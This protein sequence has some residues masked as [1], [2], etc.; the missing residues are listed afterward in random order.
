MLG[1]DRREREP[2]GPD[3]ILETTEK[4]ILIQQRIQTAHSRQKSYADL[5]RKHLEFEVEDH[6][7][8]KVSPMK[9][10]MR[11]G[12]KGK[13]SPRY[14]DPFAII[15]RVGAV[16]YELAL[17]PQFASVH[18]VFHFLLLRKY[19]P[20]SSHV[21]APQSV[22]LRSDLSYDEVPLRIIDCRVKRF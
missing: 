14:I 15:G 20:D 12:K 7:F 2:L 19:V 8:L 17:P 1:R 21:V 6:V 22:E 5:K 4:V 9:G 16:A 18:P 11:L 10:V 13:L 3:L